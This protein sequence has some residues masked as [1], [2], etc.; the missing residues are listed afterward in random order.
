MADLVRT[1]DWSATPLGRPDNW[2]LALRIT[3]RIVLAN[4]FPQLLWWGPEYISIYN[5][6][7]RPILGRKHPWALGKPVRECWSEIWEVLKP[8]IDEPF[9][10]GPATWSEDIELQL[11][12]AGFTEETH[13]T[14]AYSPVPDETAPGGIGGVLATVHEITE[15]VVGQ[16]R[17]TILRDLGTRAA[18]AQTLEEACGVLGALNSHT[19]DIPF[20]LLYVSHDSGRQARLAASCGIESF[21]HINPPIIPLDEAG[22]ANAAWPLATA[23]SAGEMQLVTDLSAKFDAVP[24]GPWTDPPASAV[25]VPIRSHLAHQFSGFLVAGLSSR[26]Q[27]DEGY[28]NFLD[29]ASSQIATAIANA[30]AYEEEHKRAEDLAELDRAKTTFFSNISHEL[31]TPLTLLLGPLETLLSEGSELAPHQRD[32]L[33]RA[34]RNSVRLLKLVNS[35]LDFSRIEAGRVS[36]SFTPTDLANFTR[37]VAS[38]FRSAMEY[39]GIEFIVDCAPLSQSV[40]VDC[41]MWEKIVLNF[42]SNAFK[43][44]FEGR[45]TLTLNAHDDYAVLTVTDTGIGIAESELPH[46]FERFHRVEG[47]KGRTYE[48][49]GIGLALVQELVKLHGGSVSVRSCPGEGSTFTV[50]IP[51]GSAHL[52]QDRIGPVPAQSPTGALAA[53]FA[54]EA[55]GWTSSQR[56]I[57]PSDDAPSQLEAPAGQ[58]PRVLLAEDNADMRDYVSRILGPHYEVTTVPDGRTALD[59]ARRS[60]PDLILTDVM[61]PRLDGFGLLRELRADQDLRDIPVILLSARAGEEARTEGI[62]AGADD[63]LTKPFAVG[64]L[65]ARVKTTL[66]LMR[67][68]REAEQQVHDSEERLRLAQEAA[69]VGS[70]DWNL[71]TNVN[72]WTPQLE[73]L[74]GLAPGDFAR[75][76]GAWEN[77]VHPDD[78]EPAR[79]RVREAFQTGAPVHGEWRAIWPDG[80]IRWLAGRFQVSKDAAGNP[81]RLSGVNFDITARKQMENDLRRSNADLEQFAYSASHDLREPL[82][83]I[84]LYSELLALRLGGKLEAEPRQLLET[85]TRN[86]ARTEALLHDLLE[87]TRTAQIEKSTAL[88]D[89]S[90]AMDEVLAALSGAIEESGARVS[91]S[92]MPPV[93]MHPAHLRQLLQNLVGNAIKYRRPGETPRVEI[94]AQHEKDGVKFSISD[95][96]IGIEKE[97]SE[98]IFGLFQRLHSSDRYSGTGLGLALCK[99]I[100]ELYNGRIWVESELEKGSTFYFTIP[101]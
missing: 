92:T 15:K 73:K 43:F 11:N 60:R 61:M 87:Y 71:Q 8:L 35:L 33:E 89:P 16:R 45:I 78:R 28:R 21:G 49:A 3:V 26:L 88:V 30:K 23:R 82:R 75:T 94:Q 6:A 2:S 41:D 42:L 99:R 13:F 59:V 70:F 19:K 24:R 95:N 57:Y 85:V 46:I 66:E 90:E 56:L 48:G 80:T 32:E 77:L 63:Y 97:H 81:V 40:Y 83:T 1:L 67:I 36:A 100:V 14:I 27:F 68:R 31:R 12:R 7:Y 52:P 54:G 22:S 17:I 79:E 39:A 5:D 37:Y 25:I 29:L 4:R 84:H 72:T 18:T 74:Y 9:N 101:G 98:R 53:A 55:L 51:F 76:Q 47:A 38:N 64:E 44:T 91:I 93:R 34:H 65:R 69:G 50:M 58:R 20:A 62:A 10:G 96:G 86:V